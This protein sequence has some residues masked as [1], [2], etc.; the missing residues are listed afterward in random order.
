MHQKGVF[1]ATK[2]Y[3]NKHYD[4][5]VIGGGPIGVELAQIFH[6]LGAQVTL[7][8]MAPHI[9]GGVD[10]DLALVGCV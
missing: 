8:E 1:P 10:E 3:M 6:A 7:L 2:D 5:L 9:L 4:V